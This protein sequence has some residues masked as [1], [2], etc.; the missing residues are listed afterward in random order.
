[1]ALEELGGLAEPRGGLGIG[2][3]RPRLEG[4]VE[5]RETSSSRISLFAKIFIWPRSVTGRGLKVTRPRPTNTRAV[6]PASWVLRK[7]VPS[8]IFRVKSSSSMV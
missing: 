8:S 1:V 6:G 4:P 2:D 3:E 7:N 5:V